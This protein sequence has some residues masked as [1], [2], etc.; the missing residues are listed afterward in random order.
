MS[1]LTRRRAPDTVDCW[2]IFFGDVQVGTISRRAGVPATAEQWGWRCGFVPPAHRGIHAEG[3]AEDFPDARRQFEAA[4][5]NLLPAC[6]GDDFAEYRYAQA[7]TA[8]GGEPIDLDGIPRGRA[9]YQQAGEIVGAE[10]VRLWRLAVEATRAGFPPELPDGSKRSD[11][12]PPG[13][14]PTRP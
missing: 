8:W 4:W 9:G 5:R 12:V 10:I 6:T 1:E 11:V 3:T 13:W 14:R 2:L 7:W